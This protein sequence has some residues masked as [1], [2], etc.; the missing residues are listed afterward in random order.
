M[1]FLKTRKPG[2]DD[3]PALNARL[4][5]ITSRGR[6]EVASCT[7]EE[8]LAERALKRLLQ[9]LGGSAVENSRA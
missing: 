4:E 5:A 7:P 6:G 8:P 9:E 3:N 1:K 2:A